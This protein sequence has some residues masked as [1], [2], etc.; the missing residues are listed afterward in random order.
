VSNQ[1]A[2]RPGVEDGPYALP[3]DTG[4]KHETIL[5][6]LPALIF[7][8]DRDNRFLHVNAAFATGLG[9]SKEQIE[10]KT[11]SELWPNESEDYWRDDREVI[12]TGTP[13]R[14][15]IEWV[16][17]PEGTKWFRTDKVP[18]K[19]A[20]GDILGVIGL[21]IDI[22]DPKRAEDAAQVLALTDELTGLNNRRGFMTLAEQQIRIAKR[23]LMPLH[24]LYADMDGLKTLNDLMGHHVGDQMIQDAARMLR[25][26]FRESDIVARIGGDEFV[27]L[28]VQT[29]GHTPE[30]FAQRLKENILFHNKSAARA[31]LSMS[32]GVVRYNP[33]EPS[34]IE[35]LLR[36][37]DAA[38]YEEKR[39]KNP[40]R[41]TN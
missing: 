37:G 12:A 4:G 32:V 13:K 22:T 15:I 27:V 2:A 19:D 9:L 5:D 11:C 26:T 16:P 38:M 29:D 30:E 1:P 40:L 34:S 20:K 21:S 18:Y 35:E 25:T 23:T 17:T 14:G 7:Y 10:G 39:A 24:L 41:H 28:M 3:P 31:Q 36:L 33:R 8:K 6:A